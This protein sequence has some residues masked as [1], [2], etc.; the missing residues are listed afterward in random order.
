MNERIDSESVVIIDTF[1]FNAI[2]V[3]GLP[4]PTKEI[5]TAIMKTLPD[6]ESQNRFMEASNTWFENK[7]PIYTD[8]KYIGERDHPAFEEMEIRKRLVEIDKRECEITGFSFNLLR[9]Y[10]ALISWH[11]E[12]RSNETSSKRVDRLKTLGQ[13]RKVVNDEIP[14]SSAKMYIKETDYQRLL[15]F[16]EQLTID[17]ILPCYEYLQAINYRKFHNNTIDSLSIKNPEIRSLIAEK[18]DI[19]IKLS[20]KCKADP[21]F[22]P[23]L[24][25]CPVCRKNKFIE[26]DEKTPNTCKSSK[27]N[28]AYSAAT[29]RKSSNQPHAVNKKSEKPISK[30]VKVDDI[31]RWC[32]S[33]CGKRRRV[34]DEQI[35]KPCHDKP[36]QE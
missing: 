21:L 4:V 12:L 30:W 34:N 20:E 35:C 13:L 9:Y 19:K 33:T 28:K 25:T 2:N 1:H 36:D 22:T 7:Y 10:K 23:R 29:T 3:G 26:K 24:F 18:T 6:I 11:E 15:R 16:D 17:E 31:Y 8:D 5:V 32:K 14:L 27:C